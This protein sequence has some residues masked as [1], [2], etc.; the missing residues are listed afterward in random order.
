MFNFFNHI[1]IKI[2]ETSKSQKGFS[3]IELLIYI[4]ILGAVSGIAVGILTTVTKTQVQE[5]AMTDVSGQ[6]GFVTQTI[7]RLV[8]DSSVIDMNA[9]V[10]SSTLKL[11]MPN[12]INDPTY[13]YLSNGQV[14]IQQGT[15]SPQS[16][17]SA[18]INID[19]LQFKKISQAPGKDTVQID[20]AASAV[21]KAAGTTISRALR[22]AVARV[23]AATFDSDLLPN[24]DNAYSVGANPSSRWL[25]G[26]FS[27]NL[28]IGGNVGIGT[29][30]PGQKLDVSGNINVNTNGTNALISTYQGANSDGYNIFIGGGGQSSIGAVGSTY[31]GS[32]NT[33]NGV[34]ALQSNTTGYYNTANGYNALFF[35]TTG[36]NNTANGVGALYSNTTGYGNTVNGLYALYY[37]TTGNSNTVNG[38][39]ALQSNTTGYGNSANGIYALYFNTTGYYNTANGMRAGMYIANGSTRNQTSTNSV[40]EGYNASPLADGDTNEIVIGASSIGNGSNS[41]TLGNTSITKTILQG[42]V[43]IG[44]TTPADPLSVTSTIG[45]YTPSGST[46]STVLRLYQNNVASNYGQWLIASRNTP[47]LGFFNV[48]TGAD[49]LT[50]TTTT[51]SLNN[52]TITN[53]GTPVNSTD[54][55]TKAYVDAAAGGGSGPTWM[56]YTGLVT[57]VLG[58][59][60]TLG[61]RQGNSLCNSSY[62]G[63]HWASWDEIA[64]LGTNYPYTYTVWIRDAVAGVTLI[65]SGVYYFY[66]KGGYSYQGGDFECSGWT[67]STSGSIGPTLIT[68]GTSNVSYCNATHNLAC[69]K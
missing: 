9:G 33:A 11:R 6:L 62:P 16:I 5:S 57:G 12:L 31:L 27:G 43:G 61:I 26:A 21:Q 3:L 23:N 52:N 49:E 41:V 1:K 68:N 30:N 7:Q 55:A 53:L 39:Q 50:L 14:Y 2:T 35:N 40:Y 67:S 20:I 66:V 8:T 37:N 46:N 63:S 34:G 47:N 38:T 45:V 13:V 42:N 15:N 24:T 36:I 51:L 29:I 22:T 44:I 69:V 54:A 56:G 65:G 60:S 18:S 19:S 64:R 58:G 59:S 25:N 32:Y 17:T 4:A 28:T 10:A 48:G